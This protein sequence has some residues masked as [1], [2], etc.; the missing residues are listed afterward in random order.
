MKSKVAVLLCTLILTMSFSGI[1][2]AATC[3]VCGDSECTSWDHLKRDVTGL[4]QKVEDSELYQSTK[5]KTG[6]IYEAAKEKAPE[7]VAQAK[8]KIPEVYEEVKD[9]VV[10]NAPM[11]YDA[12]KEKAKGARKKLDEFRSEQQNQFWGYFEQQ[13]G[14]NTGL[15]N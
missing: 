1:A 2:Y 10:E 9:T 13:T 6:A 12:A 3:E 15:A 14:Y 8:E 4:W 11:V 5:T 7:V